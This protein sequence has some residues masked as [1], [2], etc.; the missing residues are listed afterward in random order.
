MV[1]KL[2]LI[3]L[4][5][6]LLSYPVHA[7]TYYI[8]YD[9]GSD[10]YDG[11][12]KTHTT[13]TTGPWKH[14]PGMIGSSDNVLAYETTNSSS[15]NTDVAGDSFIFKGGVTWTNDCFSWNWR[16]GGG[17]GWTVG[18]DAV[19]FGVDQTWY[20]GAS[21]TRPIFDAQG[22]D[23]TENTKGSPS[24]TCSMV[25]FYNQA[26]GVIIIDNLE[27]T[28]MIH[29]DNATRNSPYEVDRSMVALYCSVVEMKNCYLHG[30]SHAAT[31]TTEDYYAPAERYYEAWVAGEDADT[32]VADNFRVISTNQG[33]S[34]TS[35]RLHDNYIDGSDASPTPGDMAMAW[36]GKAT[37]FYN[38]YVAYVQNGQAAFKTNFIFG[39]TFKYV[40]TVSDFDVTAHHQVHEDENMDGGDVYIFNN[41]V[42]GNRFGYDWFMYPRE[43][44]D[45][46]IFN[47][48]S[49]N[50]ISAMA[51]ISNKYQT[52]GNTT[53]RVF[54]N[55]NENTSTDN[56][57]GIGINASDYGYPLTGYI[58]NNHIINE[59]SSNYTSYLSGVTESNEAHDTTANNATDGYTDGSDYAF[60]PTLETGAT[61]GTGTNL[62]SVCSG[63]SSDSIAD[64]ATA[65]TYDTTY[66]VEINATNHTIVGDGRTAV[67][68]GATWDIGAYEYSNSITLSGT[69]FSDFNE[70]DVVTGGRTI[71]A[72]ISGTTWV[73]DVCTTY[74][75]DVRNGVVS[76][77][78]ETYGWNNVAQDNLTCSRDSDTQITLTDA[79]SPTYGIT[80]NDGPI[81]FTAATTTNEVGVEIV[82]S[83]TFTVGVI[84][85]IS[86][87]K[88]GT[89]NSNG[90]S[91]VITS[92]G[93]SLKKN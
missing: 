26:D 63:F 66:G 68:R 52:A 34:I 30:W 50:D 46:F 89:Q 57:Y 84:V 73:S 24:T 53:A 75:A 51:A 79:A 72:I 21:W 81:T 58:Q 49:I 91:K 10:A 33:S 60:K 11:T 6:L 32:H 37:Y 86:A 80:V 13:G 12:E 3:L 39:N 17:T 70:D 28:G 71:I 40:A 83:P 27:F 82:A 38:N 78:N 88:K 76:A 92:G 14:A 90:T 41:F 31:Y 8:D 54:N 62:S 61:V 87:S 42:D 4:F 65:C 36:K 85:D 9:N 69:A 77:Q 45:V 64:P 29:L 35:V 22:S 19:Y 1:N 74:L 18:V 48:V 7:T 56:G 5:I 25:K 20:D 47:N 59:S 15:S 55:T 44:M 23:I 2:L 67:L 43:G 16:N 93:R